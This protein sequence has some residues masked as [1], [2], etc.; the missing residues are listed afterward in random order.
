MESNNQQC[1]N[2]KC[3]RLPTDFIGKRGNPVKRCIKCRDK[4]DRQKKRPEVREKKNK[5]MKEKQYYKE[6]RQKKREQD[7]TAF[8]AHNAKV[9][10]EWRS[11]NKEHVSAWGKVNLNV[12][13][14]SIYQQSILK[15]ISWADEMTKQVCYD[16]IQ[17]P[18][19][20]CGQL[21]QER[22]NGIDRMDSNK[23]YSLSNCVP[24][25]KTCN[26]IKKS[27]DACTFI[28]R[29]EHISLC[30]GSHGSLHFD[31][32]PS[33]RS[34][35]LSSYKARANKKNLVFDLTVD[36][37]VHLVNGACYYCHRTSTTDHRNGID[38]LD[39]ARGYEVDNCVSCCGE[40]NQMKCTLNK[41]EFISACANVA[42]HADIK[43]VPALDVC[44]RAITKRKKTQDHHTPSA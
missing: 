2:C 18:C 40:C 5:L 44:L 4:D 41:D 22:L 29:C 42:S 32:W 14:S 13:Y 34:V 35:S 31:A 6:H 9:A 36:V 37:F 11:K 7:E 23:G 25:C 38:R 27:L 3:W 24:C 21:N 20:Y 28:H 15:G 33:T 10:K 19:F 16:M 12:R 30:H 1:T 39:G 43:Q 8:L 26:F 17:N